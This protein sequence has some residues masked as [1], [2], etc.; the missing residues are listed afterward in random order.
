MISLS[1]KP[2]TA[3]LKVIVTGIALELVGL[4]AVEEMV[5]EGKVISSSFIVNVTCCVPSSTALVGVPISI[6]MVSSPSSI[7]SN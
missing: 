2:V 3:S 1:V 6:I 7:P 4:V 5:G